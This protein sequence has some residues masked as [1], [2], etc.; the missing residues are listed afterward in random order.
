MSCSET[1]ER[2]VASDPAEVQQ[3]DPNYACLSRTT[4]D[5]QIHPVTLGSTEKWEFGCKQED[6]CFSDGFLFF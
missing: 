4:N 3:K 1:E 6:G 2:F 5:A